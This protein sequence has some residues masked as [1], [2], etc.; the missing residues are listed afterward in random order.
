MLATIRREKGE[1]NGGRA[2]GVHPASHVPTT[3]LIL[4]VRVEKS[5]GK[6]LALLAV[7][8]LAKGKVPPGPFGGAGHLSDQIFHA[9]RSQALALCH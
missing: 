8:V 5:E 4:P 7:P 1:D 2:R 9:P 3:Y 6:K